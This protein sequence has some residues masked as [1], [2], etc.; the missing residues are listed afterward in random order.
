MKNSKPDGKGVLVG[1]YAGGPDH[2][3]RLK[4]LSE[5]EQ[6]NIEADRAT[7]LACPTPVR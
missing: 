4:E 3:V 6:Q 7:S 2:S 5:E 1:R